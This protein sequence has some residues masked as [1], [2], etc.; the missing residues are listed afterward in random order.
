MEA[1]V[2]RDTNSGTKVRAQASNLAKSLIMDAAYLSD[3]F[4]RIPAII[5]QTRWH[6]H[7]TT[8]EVIERLYRRLGGTFYLLNYLVSRA[9]YR[10]SVNKCF[11]PP[12][13]LTNSVLPLIDMLSVPL[14]DLCAIFLG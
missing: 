13:N 12:V 11:L 3:F 2:A 7:G 5:A 6:I 4:D 1:G 14:N 10:H 8:F 9:C